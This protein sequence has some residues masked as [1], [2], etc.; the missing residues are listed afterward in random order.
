M[1]TTALSRRGFLGLVVTSGA[2]VGVG[3]SLAGCGN[4]KAK[5]TV[6]V[7]DTVDPQN[8]EVLS[9]K[10]FGT[11]LSALTDGKYTVKVFPNGTLG[12]HAR[13]NEQLRSGTLQCAKSNVADLTAFDKKLGVFALPYAFATK[14][15]L[16]AA[17]DGALGKA[18]AKLLEKYGLKIIGWFDSGDRN[19]YNT[20]HAVHTPDDMRGLKIRVQQDPVMIDTFKQLG[21]E[22]TPID[23]NQIYSA[24]QQG[25]VDAAE[26]SVI[27]YVQEHHIEVAK[28]FSWTR[29][30]FSVDP[31]MVSTTWLKTLPSDVQDAI[32]QAGKETEQHERKLWASTTG[33]YIDKAKKDGATLNDADVAAFKKATRPVWDRHSKQFGDLTTHLPGA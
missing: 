16:Y 27:F 11:R 20:K 18:Y 1:D 21:A 6:R 33:T 26:N 28:H 32:L 2:A 29:H 7:G 4:A 23:T 13:M 10:Y 14:Q 30:F 5:G 24:L 31:L 15:E 3:T 12:S 25:V 22:P 17:Q 19:V 9:E 8:P